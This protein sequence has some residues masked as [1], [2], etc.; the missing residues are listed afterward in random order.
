[1]A[2]TAATAAT[3]AAAAVDLVATTCSPR[4]PQSHVASNGGGAVLSSGWQLVATVLDGVPFSF[5]KF[6]II[7][8]VLDGGRA[9][10]LTA[11][12]HESDFTQ[13]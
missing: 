9:L 3:A 7:P 1:M 5:Q 4:S 8:R 13:V 12:F 6:N 2:T 11:T 10:Q